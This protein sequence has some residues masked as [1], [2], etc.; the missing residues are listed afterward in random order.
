MY[1]FPD[2]KTDHAVLLIG[3]GKEAGI[4]YWLVKNSWSRN[5]GD[6][7]FI[8]IKQGLCGIEKRPF[9]V[10][11]KSKKPLP[12]QLDKT[13]KKD[14]IFVPKRHRYHHYW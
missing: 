1:F 13:A 9:V 2:N 7:G 14:E 3:Y 5:W 4:P 12:W 11:N 8:K 6:H 10:L